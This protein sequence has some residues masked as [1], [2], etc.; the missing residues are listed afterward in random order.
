VTGRGDLSWRR[1]APRAMEHAK[2]SKKP[3]VRDA[4]SA[5]R[6]RFDPRP[7]DA[8][9]LVTAG[10]P[11]VGP[12]IAYGKDPLGFLQGCRRRYG[13][14]FTIDF[15]FYRAT[16]VVGEAEQRA[17]F[18]AKEEVLDLR[19]AINRFTTSVL[20]GELYDM[21]E[22]EHDRGYQLIRKGLMKEGAIAHY[23]A[24]ARSE[25]EATFER[26]ADAG[27][28]D[29]FPAASRLVTSINLRCFLGADV[30]ARHGEAFAKAYYD[31]ERWGTTPLAILLPSVPSRDVRRARAARDAIRR[32]LHTIVAERQAEIASG[33]AARRTDYLQLWL[34]D[35]APD[36]SRRTM[37]NLHVHFLSLLFAAHTNTAGTFAWALAS[38]LHDREAWNR[39]VA[40]QAGLVAAMGTDL[41]HAEIARLPYLDGCM[42]EAVRQHFTLMLVRQ[43]M[44]PLALPSCVVPPGDMV[45]VAPIL[46]HLDPSIFPEP[47]RF[48]PERWSADPVAARELANRNV[49]V[50]FGY[51]KHRCLGEL[52]ANLV[53][54]TCWSVLLRR[55]DL[56]P[57]GPPPK[58]DWTKALGTPFASGPTRV[59][60]RRRSAAPPSP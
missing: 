53:L 46:L 52:F 44:Q 25:A 12:A 23:F 60:V 1:M 34:D 51:G 16:Y 28:I 39:A 37:A 5:V 27:E 41:G 30:L 43:C 15:L 18:R 57:L 38:L 49:Y 29:L 3:T 26:W 13:D 59:R 4:L 48:R 22:S 50:Q 14:V 40:E 8:P 24:D 45:C 31:V 19:P 11:V 21:P 55:Y 10:V 7:A 17:F 36:G 2:L 6:K 47:D 20:G 56:E 58:P 32:S 54:K 9:A 35:V 42:K 33:A